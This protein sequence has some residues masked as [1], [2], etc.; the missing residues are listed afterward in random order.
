MRFLIKYDQIL[1][2]VLM[3]KEVAK[4][5]LHVGLKKNFWEFFWKEYH[6]HS[7]YS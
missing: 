6:Q 4:N 3:L 5:V 2:P 1:G 7:V